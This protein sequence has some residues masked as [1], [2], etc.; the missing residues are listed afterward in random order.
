VDFPPPMRK[1]SE[2]AKRKIAVVDLGNVSLELIQD[3]TEDGPM[4]R[5]V[6]YH[7][8]TIHHFCLLTDDIETDLEKMK[9]RAVEFQ[10]KRPKIGLRGKKCALSAPSALNGI[11]IELS[12]P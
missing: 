7:G 2:V 3:L 6:Q 4:A 8:N 1:E 10:D 9:D 5:M 12:E 11:P